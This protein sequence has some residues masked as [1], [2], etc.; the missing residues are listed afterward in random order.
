MIYC[1]QGL[2][3]VVVSTW[4]RVA[5]FEQVVSVEW[6]RSWTGEIACV[7]QQGPAVCGSLVCHHMG[8]P[9]QGPALAAGDTTHQQCWSVSTAQGLGLRHRISP[10]ISQ[11]ILQ[12]WLM[13]FFCVTWKSQLTAGEGSYLWA[14]RILTS[15]AS[16]NLDWG[17]LLQLSS[18]EFHSQWYPGRC[19]SSFHRV[20]FACW[21]C[22]LVLPLLSSAVPA[23]AA[24]AEPDGSRHGWGCLP[25]LCVG[26]TRAVGVGCPSSPPAEACAVLSAE[27]RQTVPVP[28]CLSCSHTGCAAFRASHTTCSARNFSPSVLTPDLWV[29]G[30]ILQVTLCVRPR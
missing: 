12:C 3:V 9:A 21:Q 24:C 1:I 10:G 14:V 30:Y 13:D 25:I 19:C 20:P 7:S 15:P 22:L 18:T 26:R 5:V 29:K 17:F 2:W 4:I 28:C 6:G 11:I 27:H 23:R 8:L 16:S